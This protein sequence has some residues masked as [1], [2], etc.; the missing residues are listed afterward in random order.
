MAVV[1]KS[2]KGRLGLGRIVICQILV[3]MALVTNLRKHGIV[4]RAS[5]FELFICVHKTL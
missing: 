5:H 3:G 2:P 1:R 4:S